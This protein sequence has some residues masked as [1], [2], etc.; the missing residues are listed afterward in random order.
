MCGALSEKNDPAYELEF[1]LMLIRGVAVGLPR[2]RLAYHICRGNWTRNE[3][4]AL[5]GDYQ[6]LLPLLSEL[7]VQT[8]FLEFCTSRAGQLEILRELPHKFRVGVGVVN[9]KHSEV[10]ST[11]EILA[12]AEAAVRLLGAERVLLTPDCGFAT[13]ADSPISAAAV[14]EAKLSAIAEAARILKQPA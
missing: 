7:P 2:E 14:A 8:V 10:E 9:Q 11:R 4:A 3:S 1:A 13:F 12:R 6:P 5:T